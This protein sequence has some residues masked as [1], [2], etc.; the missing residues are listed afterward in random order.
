RQISDT[1]SVMRRGRVVESGPVATLFADPQH[2]Y[3]QQLL[4]AVPGSAVPGSADAV[5]TPTGDRR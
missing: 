3:T 5:P 4:S 1:V 2:E